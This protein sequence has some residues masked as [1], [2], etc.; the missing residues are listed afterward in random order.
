YEEEY[1]GELDG[2]RQAVNSAK[3]SVFSLEN[4]WT[5]HISSYQQVRTRIGETI[6]GLVQECRSLASHYHAEWHRMTV[7]AESL[8]RTRHMRLNVLTEAEI[9]QIGPGRTKDLAD[10]NIFTAADID[11]RII[12]G[13][14]GFGD[15]RIGNLLAWK[16]EVNRQ[17]RFNPATALSP[18]ELRPVT[19]KFR[20]RQ[21]Q[22]I[23]EINGKLGNVE[24]LTSACRLAVD[25]LIPEL[26]R[27]M[28]LYEQ[29]EA[30]LHWLD[31]KR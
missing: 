25:K 3:Q 31:R 21:Q 13:I 29:A 18:A 12:R 27:V 11:E 1:N 22:L 8:A 19:V 9:P 23:A 20:T 24:S 4:Q 30:D 26:Q 16:E 6:A 28:A 7:S 10:N 2:R 14:K 5:N 17:F 15:V